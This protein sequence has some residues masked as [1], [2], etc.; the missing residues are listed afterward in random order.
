M[1]AS[2]SSQA[3]TEKP[4]FFERPISRWL[5]ILSIVCSLAV[6]VYAGMVQMPVLNVLQLAL[7][8]VP[9]SIYISIRSFALQA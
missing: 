2:F 4:S 1:Q 8:M 3:Y 5:S 7:F 6:L 9:A